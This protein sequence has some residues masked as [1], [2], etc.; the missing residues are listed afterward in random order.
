MKRFKDI[1]MNQIMMSELE[2]K[3]DQLIRK[4]QQLRSENRTLIHRLRNS[5]SHHSMM[6]EKNKMTVVT[7]KKIISQLKEECNE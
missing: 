3:I 4:L 7:V 6:K 1:Q 2:V 5:E